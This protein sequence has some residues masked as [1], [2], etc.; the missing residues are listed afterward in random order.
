MQAMNPVTV[1]PGDLKPRD[2]LGFKIVAVIGGAGDWAAYEGLTDWSDELVA[3]M[4]DKLPQDVAEM[5]FTAPPRAGL[6]YRR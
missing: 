6:V 1:R 5:L 3:K 4:G 2:V